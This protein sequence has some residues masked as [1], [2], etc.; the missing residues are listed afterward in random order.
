MKILRRLGRLALRSILRSALDLEEE[1]YGLF[2]ALPAELMGL[3]LPECVRRIMAEEREHQKL[4]RD[5]IGGH[6]PDEEIEHLVAGVGL[7]VHD[8]QAV[9]PV[10][11]GHYPDLVERLRRILRQEE[12]IWRFFSSLREKSRLPF[13][14]RAFRFLSEQEEI[15]VLML[16]RLLGV[17]TERS[18]SG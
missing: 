17:P 11:A 7:Q 10:P 18:A 4:L 3:E 9:T 2:E 16:R 5:M 14:R 1:I 13:A 15:H 8:L 12:E 6:L